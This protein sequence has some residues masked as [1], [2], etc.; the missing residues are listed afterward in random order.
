LR[1]VERDGVGEVFSR[2][3]LRHQRLIRGRVE[4]HGDAGAKREK[5]NLID[6]DDFEIRQRG[7]DESKR[8][9]GGLRDHEHLALVHVVS[10]NAADERKQQNRK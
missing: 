7:H 3:K 8:H 9:H 5:N 10:N 4:R 2:N 1:R 6:V